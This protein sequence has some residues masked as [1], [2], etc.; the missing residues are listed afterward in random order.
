MEVVWIL[1]F[2][3]SQKFIFMFSPTFKH[4]I[5]YITINYYKP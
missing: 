2:F 5:Q 4:A 1:C 3:R